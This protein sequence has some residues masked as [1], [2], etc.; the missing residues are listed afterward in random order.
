MALRNAT[1]VMLLSVAVILGCSSE[2]PQFP[3]NKPQGAASAATKEDPLEKSLRKAA[4]ELLDALRAGRPQSFLDMCSRNGID[5]GI[6]GWASYDAIRKDFGVREGSYCHYFD[7]ACL[8]REVSTFRRKIGH[9]V[10]V[11]L[12][13]PVSYRELVNNVSGLEV[14]H[15]Q[16]MRHE[17]G[18]VFG[19]VTV[20]WKSPSPRELGRSDYLDFSFVLEDNE[21]RLV[22]DQFM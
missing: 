20:K 21:W 2:A 22:S 7:T 8:Q 3:E 12:P 6:D 11:N 4:E 19:G 5:I 18:R 14:A 17:D 13:L 1:S 15:A 9:N 10:A 16:V